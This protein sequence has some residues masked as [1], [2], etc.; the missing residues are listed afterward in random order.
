MLAHAIAGELGV[1]FLKVS[2]SEI[3]S[4]VSG[5]SESKLRKIFEEAIAC[6]P[7]IIFIDEIDSIT[8]KR[9]DA[10][11]EMER[12]IVSQLLICMD[13]LTPEKTNGG[14]VMVIGA[15][16]R[17][18]ALDSALRIA[19]RFDREI[20]L[21]VPDEAARI[22]ILQVLS[23][24][25][26]MEG[27][28]D[29]SLIAKRTPGYVGAD[30]HALIKEAAKI[31]IDRIFAEIERNQEPQEKS[32]ESVNKYPTLSSEKLASFAITMADFENA[33]PFVQPSAMREGFATIPDVTWE[34]VGALV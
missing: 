11:R 10:S 15:T 18:D 1:P 9:Q 8:P 25:L 20:C 14:V 27:N 31:S 26:R 29:F 34:S 4:G 33:I 30:I 5:E 13:D 23:K 28:F 3:I 22:R 24:K 32:A 12:R 21:G 16:S 2:A 19:G 6:A 7:S 17:P